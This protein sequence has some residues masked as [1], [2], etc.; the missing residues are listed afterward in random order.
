MSQ[1]RWSATPVLVAAIFL[2]AIPAWSALG[3]QP[4]SQEELQMTSEPSAPG[5]PAIILYREVNR[6]DYGKNYHGGMRLVGEQNDPGRSEDNYYRI[7]ILTDAG[8]SQANLEIRY[9]KNLENI[10][11]IRARTIR[12]DGTIQEFDGKV[13][14]KT[15]IKN[16]NFK[17]EAKTFVLPDVQVG[18]IIEYFYT[19]NFQ[20]EYIPN[21]NWILSQDLFTKKSKI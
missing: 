10:G 15:I 16:K 2:S 4:V 3:F 7:K 20:G 18:S 12:P 13:Y 9:I 17:Y 6:D 14:D 1:L 21:S 11:V 19:I 5:A 8:R